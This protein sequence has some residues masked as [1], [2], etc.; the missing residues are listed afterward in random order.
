MGCIC[1]S[2]GSLVEE[3]SAVSMGSGWVYIATVNN[4]DLSGGDKIVVRATDMPIIK[5]KVLK[6]SKQKSIR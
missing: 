2:D 5:R 6:T 1:N 4:T 3:G